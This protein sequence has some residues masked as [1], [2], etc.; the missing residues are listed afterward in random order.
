MAWPASSVCVCVGVGKWEVH[1]KVLLYK[2][3]YIN[4]VRLPFD[5]IHRPALIKDK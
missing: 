2:K 1:C 4:A 5:Y 3:H